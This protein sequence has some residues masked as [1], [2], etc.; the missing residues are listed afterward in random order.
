[1]A[2]GLCDVVQLRIRTWS[3]DP[4]PDHAGSPMW[5]QD[6]QEGAPRPPPQVRAGGG[7]VEAE[8]ARMD[9]KVGQGS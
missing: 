1:M 7:R 3:K 6:L 4:I 9:M 8:V 5:S 2:K